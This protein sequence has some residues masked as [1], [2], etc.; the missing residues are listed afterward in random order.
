MATGIALAGVAAP[1]QATGKNGVLENGEFGLYYH[2]DRA[3]YVFDL[4]VSDDDFSNDNFP[5]T[6]VHANDNT[7]SY[8]NR[9]S[10]YWWV[11]TNAGWGGSVG[12]LDPGYTGNAS[13]TFRN[14]ISSARFFSY[15]C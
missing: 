13:A 10:Y 1:A 14:K 2:P 11:Y 15:S 7:A 5:N 8:D 9:D 3:G 6:S 4:F 12:C